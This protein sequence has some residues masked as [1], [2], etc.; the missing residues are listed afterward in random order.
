MSK[1]YVRQ[2][3]EEEVIEVIGEERWD[4][5]LSF[6]R[7]QTVIINK[8]G[9]YKYHTYDVLRFMMNKPVVD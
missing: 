3:N 7:G 6:M 8:D 1:N 4:E 9:S 2:M 5:F